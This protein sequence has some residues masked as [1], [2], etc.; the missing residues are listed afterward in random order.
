[1]AFN[2]H[3][4]VSWFS[5]MAVWQRWAAY[6]FL[7]VFLLLSII[8]TS[9]CRRFR[10]I[11]GHWS[12]IFNTATVFNVPSHSTTVFDV[13]KLQYCGY[14][15]KFNV[16]HDCGGQAGGLTHGIAVAHI[17]LACNASALKKIKSLSID[18]IGAHLWAFWAFVMFWCLMLFSSL[19][20]L[21]LHSLA[22]KVLID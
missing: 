9:V 16:W 4:S 22:N 2:C 18:E 1:V 15:T 8:T 3:R 21:S 13:R 14:K 12:G 6:D 5:E 10:P 17:A 20:F 19:I 7:L 11:D